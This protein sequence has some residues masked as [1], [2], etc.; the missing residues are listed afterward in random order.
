VFIKHFETGGSFFN[1]DP[2]RMKAYYDE[3][4]KEGKE[5]ASDMKKEAAA[6]KA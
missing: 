6:S 2:K 4:F 1:F 3:K 5:V